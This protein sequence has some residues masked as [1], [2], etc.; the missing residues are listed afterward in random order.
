M[1]RNMTYI[2]IIPQPG[3][4]NFPKKPFGTGWSGWVSKHYAELALGSLALMPEQ[5]LART[6][7]MIYVDGKRMFGPKN[8]PETRPVPEYVEASGPIQPKCPVYE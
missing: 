5:A 2:D 3:C 7:D 1:N 6:V 4:E 8:C